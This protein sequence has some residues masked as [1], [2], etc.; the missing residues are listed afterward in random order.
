M[1]EE[2]RAAYAHDVMVLKCRGE[3]SRLNFDIEDFREIVDLLPGL[4]K[5]CAYLAAAIRLTPIVTRLQW[6]GKFLG[7]QAL[8][9]W[10][11]Q[12]RRISAPECVWMLK[13]NKIVKKLRSDIAR[14]PAVGRYMNCIQG[15]YTF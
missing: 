8:L 3:G 6:S 13:P 1:Q 15:L 4:S 9:S 5:V 14:I 10:G 2:W 12:H 7:N 11:L